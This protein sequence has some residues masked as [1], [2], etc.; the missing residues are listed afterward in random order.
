MHKQ[1]RPQARLRNALVR[2]GMRNNLKNPD[3]ST[4]EH[5]DELRKL[6]WKHGVRQFPP[7]Q[8]HIK[9]YKTPP[10]SYNE[11]NANPPFLWVALKNQIKIINEK[12]KAT[13]RLTLKKA[14]HTNISGGSK[15]YSGGELWFISKNT[16]ILNGC[17]GRYGPRSEA[18]LNEIIDVFKATGWITISPG[19][20]D[21]VKRP[22]KFARTL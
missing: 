3:L 20:D 16:V 2:Y 13:T 5:D 6:K 1:T 21:E 8:N 11:L 22:A 12:A 17:S 15:A 9:P 18:Q 19:W 14:K 4:L 7:K 10:M